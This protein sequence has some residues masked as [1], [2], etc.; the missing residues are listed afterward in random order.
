MKKPPKYFGGLF[1]LAYRFNKFFTK[2]IIGFNTCIKISKI[3]V[4]I[5]IEIPICLRT[6]IKRNIPTVR[7]SILPIILNTEI[8]RYTSNIA[9]ATIIMVLRLILEKSTFIKTPPLF[10]IL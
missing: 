2:S 9:N 10:I 5:G 8:P 6:Y 3:S 7:L 1:I 4:N